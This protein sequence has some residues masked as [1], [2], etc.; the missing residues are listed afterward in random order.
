MSEMF[1]YC[2]SLMSLD[3]SGWDTGNVTSMFCMFNYCSGLTSLDLSGWDT[4]NV[5]S[6]FCMFNYC[7]GLTSLD[8][9][10][11]DTGNVTDMGGMFWGCNDLTSLDISTWDTG[12]VTSMFCMFSYCSGLT[13]LDLSGWDTGNVTGMEGMF[14]FCSGLT[15]LDLSGWDT[16]NVT[17][18]GG[19][20][21]GCDDLTSLDIS[22]WDTGNVTNMEG[23]FRYCR[24]LASLDLS[25]WDTENVTNMK[26]MF[27]DCNSLST[28]FCS[29]DWRGLGADSNDMFERCW[30]LVGGMGTTYNHEHTGIEYAH[31]DGGPDNPGYF[32]DNS[33]QR[34]Q[35]NIT[36]QITGDGDDEIEEG[37][38]VRWYDEGGTLLGTGKSLGGIEQGSTL[39]YSVELDE[40]P[41]RTYREVHRR[42]VV[43]EE[44]IV[45]CRL[46]RIGELTLTGLVAA[47]GL[48]VA[49]AR[50]CLA[51]WLNGKYDY[52]DEALTDGDGRFVMTAYEDSTRIVVATDGFLDYELKLPRLTN[53]DQGTIVLET[54][55]GK[56]VLFTL[57]Y[58]EAAHEGE[59][60]LVI[61]NY[62]NTGDVVYEVIN[63]TRGTTLDDCR[64]QR[65]AIV[66]PQGVEAG[67][68]LRVVARSRS[69]AFADASAECV[70][71]ASDTTAVNLL[72]VEHGGLSITYGSR[73]DDQ[74]LALLYGSDGQLAQRA[75]FS[76]RRLTMANLKAGTYQLVT[77]GNNGTV[78]SIASLGD[79]QA[80]DLEAGSDY[81]LS[82][83]TVSDGRYTA[84]TVDNVPEL[85]AAK[86][87]YTSANTSFLP[88]KGEYAIGMFA[89]LTARVD[90]KEQYAGGVDNVKLVVDLPEGCQFIDNS[91]VVD[92]IY[93]GYSLDGQRL[94]VPLTAEQIDKRVR[95]CVR[96]ISA[97]NY[98]CMAHAVFSC[99]GE[100]MQP[101][102]EACF[103]VTGQA[104]RVPRKT[105]ETTIRVGGTALPKAEVDIY[106]NN[107]LVGTTTALSDGSWQ[108]DVTLYEPYN[109]STH[110]IFA[111][112]SLD[113]QTVTTPA[114]ECIYD[115][116]DIRPRSVTMSFYNA[117]MQ[118]TVDVE[119][120]FESGQTSSNSYSFYT[121]TDFTFVADLTQN[122]TTTVKGVTFLVYTTTKEVRRL[123]GF[124]DT[125]LGRWVAVGRFNG[126]NLPV[127]LDVE[128]EAETVP[129][130]DTQKATDALQE[131]DDFKETVMAENEQMNQ[132]E[133][134]ISTLLAN[135]DYDYEE[136]VALL[137]SY[138]EA[139]VHPVED[140]DVMSMSDE[141]FDAYLEQL[142][143][144]LAEL[145]GADDYDVFVEAIEGF[146]RYYTTSETLPDGS[147][148]TKTVSSCDG[149]SAEQLLADGYTQVPSTSGLLLE[150]ST[151]EIYDY[152]DFTN[153]LRFTYTQ[154]DG[155]HAGAKRVTGWQML[156]TLIRNVIN[157]VLTDRDRLTS[158]YSKLNSER[159]F[160]LNKIV[161]LENSY[162][163]TLANLDKQLET[164][165]GLKEVALRAQRQNVLG[166]MN[167]LER[168]KA[169]M[170]RM[171]RN[172]ARINYAI[173]ELGAI[174]DLYNRLFV[175]YQRIRNFEVPACFREKNPE[176]AAILDQ[177]IEKYRG[178]FYRY[179]AW[180]VG[181]YATSKVVDI[182]IRVPVLGFVL[183]LVLDIAE[184]IKDEQFDRGTAIKFAQIEQNIEL[185][186]RKCKKEEPDEPDEPEDE[187]DPHDN[188]NNGGQPPFKD[189]TP[190]HDPSGYVFEAVPSN[191]VEDVTA[192]IY[193]KDEDDKPAWWDAEEF[194][195]V[196]PI[197]TDETGVYAWDV[198]QGQWKVTYEKAGY[199]PMETEWLPV[200]PPQ[201]EVNIPLE[202]AVPPVVTKARGTESGISL[203]FS[204]YMKPTTLEKSGRVTVKKDNKGRSGEVRMLNLEQNPLNGNEYASQVKFVPDQPFTVG[205]EV[206]VTVKKAVESYASMQM[207]QDFTARLTIEPDLHLVCDSVAAVDYQATGE[208]VVS[209]VPASEARGKTLLVDVASPLIA[210]IEQ[211]ELV[212]DENGKVCI[213]VNGQLPGTTALR[214]S[215][216][217][218]DIAATTL[219]S[220][221]VAEST[222]RT[223]KASKRSGSTVDNG[224]KLSLT[225]ATRGA[226]IW[227][228][229]DGS[230]PCDTEK[231]LRYEGPIV[232]DR[233]M[234]I[235][236][237]ATRHGMDDSDVATFT[238]HV[239]GTKVETVKAARRVVVDCEDGGVIIKGADGAV[240]SVY[241]A[242]GRLVGGL[243]TING[244]ETAV[245]LPLPG[246]YV[247]KLQ[248]GKEETVIKK[249]KK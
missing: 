14:N 31:V 205:D 32:T 146:E 120:D 143:N 212:F 246:V 165:I 84:I 9:S 177:W 217:E 16:G 2:S 26:L 52:T 7:S 72:L 245:I 53:G 96:P 136:V 184:Q 220:V 215:V 21:W 172:V 75:S 135:D 139:N 69:D 149:L 179:A 42:R 94:T 47:E 117:W 232:I 78:G 24:S 219:L 60:P 49:K 227:Y 153:N 187:E 23:I 50:V 151:D 68:C 105:A 100:K 238:Y 41:G 247:L 109:L 82:T 195:Q 194:S 216:P 103:T 6:M 243:R 12:N 36:L 81:A 155:G 63:L 134:Q 206:V 147:V 157:N 160:R 76:T 122:D 226:T 161:N 5:T 61:D 8:L 30:N 74:L 113:G 159:Q 3:L 156:E 201:L 229:T 110:D 89:T 133:A 80:M 114:S 240:L 123:K 44:R 228:T 193:F 112:V 64:V 65:D 121:E 213:T 236:A 199:E 45:T 83:A 211:Q 154:I 38:T 221:V 145:D 73:S 17:D 13:S 101:V 218:A 166:K 196:N 25:G 127:N 181:K 141:E 70:M 104:L 164:A 95:F 192:S 11:W 183:N 55:N 118:K 168:I 102:G 224:Y 46:E 4:G 43:A 106:D 67:D 170:M 97:G 66:L 18:M 171:P 115:I 185:S 131:L 140:G 235:Q 231:R 98:Q 99:G 93:S 214:F 57:Q 128:V 200:P 48:P 34:P 28:I 225:C 239:E 54:V 29:K 169:R 59:T 132:T 190:M 233:N 71:T 162:N 204:K 33:G 37:A 91:L 175:N 125:G 39:F 137:N 197:V 178:E 242:G 138:E 56:V 207:E 22:T 208:L 174:Y 189:V 108:A 234:T 144:E 222:V 19:M 10:G 223:P 124:F 241:D 107:H 130:A 209:L 163:K 86:F 180:K 1:Y 167:R 126:S 186:K 62:D 158:L 150:L 58:Q 188:G 249:V 35:I 15:S 85:D 142:D 92:N 173:N 87:E 88:G 77:L 248:F 148:F 90:F 119:F 51:Q 116:S 202:H 191:R 237:M 203:T 27:D 40:A 129:L 152:V 230:C 182:G 210:T 111:K 20:F 176:G 244:N 198:P 79:L